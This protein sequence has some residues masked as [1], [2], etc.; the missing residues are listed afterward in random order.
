MLDTITNILEGKG[1]GE[2]DIS[3][4]LLLMDSNTLN[5]NENG[6][7]FDAVQLFITE[8]KRFNIN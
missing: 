1:M 6:Q 2:N 7:I 4:E 3:I 8:S 5:Y